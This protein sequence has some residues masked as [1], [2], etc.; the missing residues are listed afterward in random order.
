MRLLVQCYNIYH[1]GHMHVGVYMYMYIF[2]RAPLLLDS[3]LL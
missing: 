3:M 1:C 2:N